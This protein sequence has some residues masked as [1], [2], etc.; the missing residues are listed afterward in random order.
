MAA[1]SAARSS[2]GERMLKS[3]T[4]H[5]MRRAEAKQAAL[6][7]AQIQLLMLPL[8]LFVVLSC[9]ADATE[10]T[11]EQASIKADAATARQIVAEK[12]NKLGNHGE[13]AYMTCR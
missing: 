2:E 9:A 1:E 12:E 8:A 7:V 4:A 3:A 6:S 5:K 11:H 10:A 13:K